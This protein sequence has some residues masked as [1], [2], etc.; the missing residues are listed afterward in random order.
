MI[1]DGKLVSNILLE[2][3]IDKNNNKI[4]TFC[5]VLVG[6]NEASLIYIKHKKKKCDEIGINFELKHFD[7]NITES[8]LKIEIE[9][10]NKNDNID[11]C[12]IQ[13]PLPQHINQNTI[14]NTLDP[15]KD[16]V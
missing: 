12:I 3:L 16:K 6:N 5:I 11:S 10:I 1:I 8:Q 14:L 13:L 2:K 7:K 15:K 9:L 4:I